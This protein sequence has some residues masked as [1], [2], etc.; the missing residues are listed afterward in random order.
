MNHQ[1]P[2]DIP[3]RGLKN[4]SIIEI[5]LIQ[6]RMVGNRQKCNQKDEKYNF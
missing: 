4:K 1:T 5:T 2:G 3:G 6:G